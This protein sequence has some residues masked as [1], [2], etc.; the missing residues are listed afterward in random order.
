MQH[1]CHLKPYVTT[2]RF[3]A[4]CTCCPQRLEEEG[5]GSTARSYGVPVT[6]SAAVLEEQMS[7]T[8][9]MVVRLGN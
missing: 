1:S 9:T 4:I 8:G 6:M 3:H 5:R 2:V 7:L